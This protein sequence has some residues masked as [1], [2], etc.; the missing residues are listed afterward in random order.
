MAQRMVKCR[1]C[2]TEKFSGDICTTPNCMYAVTP[3]YRLTGMQAPHTLAVKHGFHEPASMRQETYV[4]IQTDSIL[5]SGQ[6]WE[7]IMGTQQND[8]AVELMIEGSETSA[9]HVW[10]GQSIPTKDYS[11]RRLVAE[12]TQN[13]WREAHEQNN[14]WHKR[15]PG[16]CPS[17]GAQ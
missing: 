16:Y 11:E 8:N 10:N 7:Q 15:F 17:C 2:R 1:G 4:P 9:M 3:R 13:Y 6:E 14:D 5:I 12:N